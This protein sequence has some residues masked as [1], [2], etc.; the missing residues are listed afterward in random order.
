MSRWQIRPPPRSRRAAPRTG[1]PGPGA[2]YRGTVTEPDVPTAENSP[3][4][5]RVFISYAQDDDAHKERVRCLWALLRGNH[6]DA[7]IDG[8]AAEQPQDWPMWMTGQI[9]EADYI[10][11][12][13]SPAYRRRAEGEEEAGIGRGVAWEARQLRAIVHRNPSDWHMRILGV[14]LPGRSGD[15]LP[16][17]MT[18]GAVT[19]YEVPSLDRPGIEGLLRYLLQQP[20]ETVPPLGPRPHLPA[21]SASE[22]PSPARRR[23]QQP[24]LRSRRG[25][26]RLRSNPSRRT[27]GLPS[28][29]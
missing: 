8:P 14:V 2:R 23:K 12:I 15:D 27:A 26:P 20:S 18:G 16:S 1:R 24:P 17:F 7:Q 5:P 25:R 22:H 13:A 11:V 4:A 9:R 3:S 10:L 6:V 28:A 29:R 21:R 19:V